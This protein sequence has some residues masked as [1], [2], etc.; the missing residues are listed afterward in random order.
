MT[1]KQEKILGGIAILFVLF[2][3][4]ASDVIVNF[5]VTKIF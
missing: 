2:L 3:A 5:V 1:E 4:L